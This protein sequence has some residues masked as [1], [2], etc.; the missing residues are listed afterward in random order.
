VRLRLA[1]GSGLPQGCLDGGLFGGQLCTNSFLDLAVARRVPCCPSR[2]QG[3]STT[4]R[5]TPRRWSDSSGI[6]AR[7][8]DA[9]GL[10]QFTQISSMP[11][12]KAS[13]TDIIATRYSGSLLRRDMRR[14]GVLGMRLLG[15]VVN[16]LK[17]TVDRL[18]SYFNRPPITRRAP[19]YRSLPCDSLGIIR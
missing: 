7:H 13:R 3:R 9:A 6:K 17:S 4:A 19:R 15:R 1:S 18:F 2:F 14:L 16:T 12:I 8:L 11:N 10:G 5:P